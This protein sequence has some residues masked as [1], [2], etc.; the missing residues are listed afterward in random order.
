MAQMADIRHALELAR[1]N[2]F[3]EVELEVDDVEFSAKLDHLVPSAPVVEGQSG[4]ESP[5]E[6]SDKF[7]DIGASCVGYFQP[8]KKP[9]S[10]GDKVEKGQVVAS[11][12]ALGLVNDVESKIAGEIVDALVAPDDAVQFAQPLFRVRLNS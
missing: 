5:V 11:I 10:V 4:G 6:S 7:A 1:K 9:V 12:K 8:A 2:G 3:T